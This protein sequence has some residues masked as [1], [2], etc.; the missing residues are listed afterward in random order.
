[1]KVHATTLVVTP[2]VS[3]SHDVAELSSSKAASGQ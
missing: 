2:F 3:S 1:M